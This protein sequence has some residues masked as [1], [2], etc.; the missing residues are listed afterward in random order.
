[1]RDAYR[2]FTLIELL[3][4]IA[5]IAILAAILFPVFARAREK[6]R[7]TTCLSNVKEITLGLLMYA[8][9][10][11]ERYVPGR[12]YSTEGCNSYFYWPMLIEPYIKAG[13]TSSSGMSIWRCPSGPRYNWYC[14]HYSPYGI[15]T[16]IDGGLEADIPYPASTIAVGEGWITH[17]SNPDRL[18]GYY[19]FYTFNAY[20]YLGGYYEARGARYDHN[21]QGNFS[22]CDGHAKSGSEQSMKGGDFLI[23]PTP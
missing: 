16:H 4:V 9:D 19:L 1:M 8:S 23:D 14:G 21:E 3:V 7:Q 11:D 6:A 15:N 20:D 12:I 22:F 17:A 5:I 2:G 18:E 10:Y 13:V